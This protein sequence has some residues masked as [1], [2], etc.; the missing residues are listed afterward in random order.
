MDPATEG[1]NAERGDETRPAS[2]LARLIQ[3][4]DARALLDAIMTFVPAGLSIADASGQV[5][6]VSDYASRL[7]GRARSD[8]EGVSLERHVAAYGVHHPDLNPAHYSEVPLASALRGEAIAD[9]VWL[10]RSARGDFV[11]ILVSAGPI[12]DPAGEV[13]GGISCWLDL[14]TQ[15]K[16]EREL[17]RTAHNREIL[18][19]ELTH[20]VKNHLQII[21][22]LVSLEMRDPALTTRDLA[23]NIRAR[24]KLLAA[25]YDSM[26]H[27]ELGGRIAVAPYAEDV[28]RPYRSERVRVLV[29][30]EPRGLAISADQ[31]APFGM[32]LNEA[33]CNAYKH[34]F[35][36]R[37]G[38][39]EVCLTRPQRG[40][41]K[42]EVSDDGVGMPLDEPERSSLGL[43]L[44]KVQADQLGGTFSV[45]NR[46][47]GGTAVT[48]E[49]PEAEPSAYECGDQRHGRAS[50]H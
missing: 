1:R 29:S 49:F 3:G 48:V 20:R 43:K 15:K 5:L 7:M 47:I 25:V 40:R 2:E 42:L 44:M 45:A 8:M 13:I 46:S 27:A 31:A 4:A 41:L 28:C 37:N 18:Y 38:T 14:R 19:R 24:L 6:R 17:R 50:H 34:A 22:G 35:P 21:S 32:L 12:R 9:Q 39:V 23:E 33:V 11:P 30:E 36:G 26:S 16:L 10:V